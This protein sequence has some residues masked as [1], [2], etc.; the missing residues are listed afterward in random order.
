M[1]VAWG[2]AWEVGDTERERWKNIIIVICSL[3]LHFH[4]I[5]FAP[6]LS[7]T[8]PLMYILFTYCVT[9]KKTLSRSQRLQVVVTLIHHYVNIS[10]LSNWLNFHWHTTEKVANPYKHLFS[11]LNKRVYSSYQ[12][13][14]C[15]THLESK[16]F[17]VMQLKMLMKEI[18]FELWQQM[19]FLWLL[20]PPLILHD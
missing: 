6:F 7:F 16:A 9:G 8:H 3:S 2:R 15:S 17:R 5:K 12:L 13:T 11:C 1:G 20:C 14:N 4:H 18:F 10:R 19:D